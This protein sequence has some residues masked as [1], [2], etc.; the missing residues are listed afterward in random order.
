MALDFYGA[1]VLHAYQYLFDERF[2]DLRNPYDPQFRGA[3]D[4]YNGALEAALRLVCKDKGLLPGKT[5]TIRTA[6]GNWDITCVVRGGHWR[7]ED[8]DRFEF[9]SDYEING[10]KNHY[11]TYGLGVP[12]IAVR[13]RA[14]RASRPAASYY[15]AGLSFPGDGVPAPDAGP[16]PDGADRLGARR[17]SRRARNSTIRSTIGDIAVE[18]RPRAAGKRPD[19]AA[20]LFPL[21]SR[22]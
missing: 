17:T 22:A 6:A 10:L 15:P 5:H 21:Q 18:R 11:R 3:C 2:R 16:K 14:T 1:S 9:V 12:L 7:R 4:L 20:G 8:F 19:H 13:P